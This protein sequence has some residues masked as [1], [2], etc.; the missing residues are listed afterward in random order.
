MALLFPSSGLS[1]GLTIS[2]ASFKWPWGAVLR[3]LRFRGFFANLRADRAHAA[4]SLLQHL[5]LDGPGGMGR[6]IG[7]D[8]AALTFL[9]SIVG[10]PGLAD[11]IH[12]E[13][14]GRM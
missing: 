5:N 8:G 10:H 14:D 12:R 3:S 2:M 6:H 7:I 1:E 11:R 13:I 9:G 4:H